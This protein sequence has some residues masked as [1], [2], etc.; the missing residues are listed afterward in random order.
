VTNCLNCKSNRLTDVSA[1]CS[2]LFNIKYKDGWKDGYVTGGIGGG[3]YL[4][5]QY[6]LECG[7]IQDKFPVKDPD[8]SDM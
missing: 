8:L 1:K 2:D 7:Q 3:D 6:C 4:E 5:F